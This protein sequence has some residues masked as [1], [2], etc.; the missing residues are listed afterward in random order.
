MTQTGHQPHQWPAALWLLGVG[1]LATAAQLALTRAYARGR[2]L[3]N[4]ALQYLGVAYSFVF[5]VLIFQDPITTTALVGMLLVVGAG[6]LSTRI[7]SASSKKN[8]NPQHSEI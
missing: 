4:A 8:L 3:V 7:Q 5:G 1:L 6:L 2:S